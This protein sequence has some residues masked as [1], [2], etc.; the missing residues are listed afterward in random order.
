MAGQFS[1]LALTGRSA[2]F[3]DT[4]G[5]PGG[6]AGS[7][8]G[9]GGGVDAGAYGSDES[10]DDA[11]AIVTVSGRNKDREN[12]DLQGEY[13]RIGIHHGRPAYRKPGTRTVVR[14]WSV[15]DRWLIDREGLQ[16][17]DVCNAY[18]EQGGKR[19]PAFDDLV[20]RIWETSHRA[21]VRDPELLV[22]AAPSVVQVIGRSAGKEN[23]ALNG[24]YK[25]VGLHQGRVAYQKVGKT[26][27]AIRYWALGDRWLIDLEGLRSGVDTC[28]AYADARGT[29]HPG[30][31]TLTWH[32]WDSNS[33][34]HKLDSC[35][36]AM[37]A[38]AVVELVGREAPKE[39]VSMN[40]SYHIFGMHA[41]RPAYLKTDGSGHALRYWPREDRWLID[42]DGLRD[43]D[44]CNA[45][46]EASG[47]YEH[48]GELKIVWHVWET[49]RGRHLTDPSVRT[50]VA[51]HFVRVMGRDP[52]KE[53][54]SINGDYEL[55]T[56]VEGK[57]AYKKKDSA[58]N[59]VIRYWPAED[60]WIVDL[61]AGFHGGDIANA[62]AD[63]KGAENPGNSE[64][65]WYVW[66]TGRGRHVAD[67]DVLAEAI[68][69]PT[70]DWASV[71]GA[72]RTNLLTADGGA[73]LIK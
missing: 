73:T 18:A 24:E 35:L 57:A 67:E 16:E 69:L 19:H 33:G 2:G 53:N 30:N 51:P 34:R 55:C 44:V 6:A 52:Y 32:V 63:A 65:L 37:V 3:V 47:G 46:A 11:P 12:Q 22:T 48:P 64:L 23:W 66:E 1:G 68:W 42:L 45:Y 72:T 20:W 7:Y 56:I 21:H 13:H 58:D 27:H 43:V 54:S 25:L 14:Y 26:K 61:E 62:Y 71:R 49:S 40:G 28:N 59:H 15:A 8:G 38:P 29:T 5:A 50:F 39:N 31:V 9:L 60:R 10:V 36:Q 41:G 70:P 17:S 4:S